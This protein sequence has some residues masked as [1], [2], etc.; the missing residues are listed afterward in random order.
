[1]RH[2]EELVR[3]DVDVNEYDRLSTIKLRYKLRLRSTAFIAVLHFT[4]ISETS[5]MSIHVIQKPR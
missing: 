1:M 4:V 3:K 5:T 2:Y